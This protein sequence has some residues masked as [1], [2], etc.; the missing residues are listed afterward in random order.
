M[1]S[2]R[3]LVE[4]F[5]IAQT[6]F[7]QVNVPLRGCYPT[8]RFLLKLRF[9]KRLSDPPRTAA[10]LIARNGLFHGVIVIS[11]YIR[12]NHLGQ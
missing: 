3:C 12:V 11:L 4:D 1:L 8:S 6:L 2:L 9:E 5:G 10:S 7:D